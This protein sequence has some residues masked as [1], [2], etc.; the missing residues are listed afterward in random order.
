M[1]Q[2]ELK[3]NSQLSLIHTSDET[4]INVETLKLL[5]S[6]LLY[7]KGK[8]E[9]KKTKKKKLVW[10]FIITLILS[11]FGGLTLNPPMVSAADYPSVYV[12]PAINVN[13]TTELLYV[14]A[15]NVDVGFGD[16]WTKVPPDPYI[17][18]TGDA[19]EIY[20]TKGGD[21]IGNFTFSNRSSSD[22]PSEVYL[23]IRAK[24]GDNDEI[25]AQIW[26]GSSWTLY[27]FSGLSA[28]YTWETWNVTAILDTSSKIDGAEVRFTH[29]AAG[30]SDSVYID[31]ARLNV[32]AAVGVGSSYTIEI[33]TDYSQPNITG[34]QFSLTY[35]PDTLHVTSVANGDLVSGVLATFSAGAIDNIVGT[36]TNA[37]AYFF[38]S[39]YVVSGPGLLATVTFE[40]VGQ[41]NSNINLTSATQLNGWNATGGYVYEIVDGDTMPDHLGHGY[42]NIGGGGDVAVTDIVPVE[43]IIYNP[44]GSANSTNINVTVRN[45]G[46]SNMTFSVALYYNSSETGWTEIGDYTWAN[47]T[48]INLTSAA[49]AN[50]TV[51]WNVTEIDNGNYTL[52]AVRLHSHLN[53][54]GTADTNPA[55]DEAYSWVLVS[56]ARH[57][58]VY[59]EPAS[60]SD[61]NMTPGTNFTVSV[62]TDYLGSNLTGYQFSLTYNPDTL[63]VTSVANGDLVSGV[64][65][66]FSAGAIDNIVG[67]LTNTGAY[68][69]VSGYVVSGPGL[70]ATVTFEVVGQGNSNINLTSATQLNG[71]NATGGYAYEI[72][73]GDTMPD[74]LG[75][76]YFENG[77]GGDVAVTDVTRIPPP[78][79]LEFYVYIDP[80]SWEMININV[81]ARNNGLSN[82]TFSVALYYNY[83]L[84]PGWTEI[85][86]YTW[87]NQTVINLTSGAEANVTFSL[88]ITTVN[89]PLSGYGNYTLKAVRLHSH[90][91]DYGTADINLAN[92]EAYS[93]VY[94]KHTNHALP[95]DT[96]GDGIV[97]IFD[98][99]SISAHWYPGPPAGPLG[100]DP[101]ADL[102][103]SGSVDMS[104]INICSAH[105]GDILTP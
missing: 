9:V 41:G 80:E 5:K 7:I 59:L 37:G 78:V 20:A 21:D 83:S 48:V 2:A 6:N 69:F 88:N 33:K 17:N 16:D 30:G 13:Y 92:D 65:A 90:L 57:P 66:T 11:V 103:Y 75:H 104:D 102:N 94:I 71:W 35:N 60:L 64:L 52:K 100:Y 10:I 58:A 105:W 29:N 3:L 12:N 96:N 27:T 77:G 101:A 42:F 4:N 85:G 55:N 40:I 76:G 68:F 24:T 53:D 74:H 62:R 46:L 36:L 22:V 44:P 73:D 1:N 81:T 86:D 51:F 54:Y 49:E 87:A 31:A 26:D 43:N 25:D 28:V 79:G 15:F 98:I 50:V 99:A 67:T 39:G 63:H 82:M 47:Q 91:N 84:A 93:W 45:N 72:V 89:S 70:L 38:V 56:T 19:G 95:G 97:D 23:D 14:D 8:G 18:G 34:Y 61:P 32:T